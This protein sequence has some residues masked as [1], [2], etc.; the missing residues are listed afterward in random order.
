VAGAAPATQRLG[1]WRAALLAEA[2]GSG[3]PAAQLPVEALDPLA[4]GPLS[5]TSPRSYAD[6]AELTRILVDSGRR[7]DAVAVVTRLEEFAAL[8]PDFPFLNAAAL[9][10]RAVLDGDAGSALRAVALSAGDRRPLI[11][12]AVLE[13]AGRLLPRA[14]GAEAV[15]LLETAL[16][17]YTAAGAERDAAR[18][19][20]LLR[21]RGIRPAASGP[22]SVPEWPELTE[23]ELAVVALVTR[24]ATNRE[25]AE[26]LYLSPYT[27]NSHLRHVF[28]KLGIRSR[29]E[30]AR[31]A[32][33]RGLPARGGRSQAG[34]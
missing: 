15:P 14:R 6:T 22:R 29:V 21:A 26:R 28:S 7:A 12:A 13:D 16:A 18:V 5:P 2:D 20:G 8:H 19:R 33:E 11:R 25:V 9:H 31:L 23:S 30:L 24:G 32:A 1:A 4:T 34:G 17:A 27:V 3:P 10:A